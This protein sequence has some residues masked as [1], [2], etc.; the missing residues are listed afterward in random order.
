MYHL[1]PMG[2]QRWLIQEVV[3]AAWRY[4]IPLQ[5]YSIFGLRSHFPIEDKCLCDIMHWCKK[6][7]D[8]FVLLNTEV[9]PALAAFSFRLSQSSIWLWLAHPWLHFRTMILLWP[10]LGFESQFSSFQEFDNKSCVSFV[11]FHIYKMEVLIYVLLLL[12]RWK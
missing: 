5:D 3:N 1:L 7:K 8:L 9:F 12:W 4:T 6:R 2:A 11:S 10:R